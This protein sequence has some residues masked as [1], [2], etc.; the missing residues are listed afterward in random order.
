VPEG[1]TVWR[2]ARSLD[3][4]LAGHVLTATAFRVPALATVDLTGMRLRQTI[5]RGKHLLT[6]IDDGHQMLSL[7]THLKMEGSW[8]IYTPGQRWRRPATEAR[9]VLST[10]DRVCVGFT[11]GI[12]ELMPRVDEDQAVGHL[13][14]DLLG[15]DWDEAEAV[16]RVAA[17][18]DR[19]V[20]EALLDQRNL[21]GIGNFYR[22]ELCFLA[23]VQPFAPVHGVTDLGRIVRRAKVLLE[24]NKERAEQT[25]TGDL[26][27]G[28]RS[29]VYRQRR[30][31]RC[32]SAV[33]VGKDHRDR[34][35]YWCPSCQPTAG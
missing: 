34:A 22:N 12:V 13:G 29:W 10:S 18:P 14:P 2:A 11:L 35:I 5:S 32:D 17:Q 15:P 7:H 16:R 3:R 21:A 9:V 31:G 28:H 1:D 25:T 4:A 20:G 27:P 26:R 23:G 8:H 30:C 19:P 33:E 6:R 24:T